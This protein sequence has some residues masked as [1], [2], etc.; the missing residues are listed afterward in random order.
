M[1]DFIFI[2]TNVILP[3]FIPV[4]LGYILS[5]LMKVDVKTLSALQFYILIPALIYIKIMETQIDA[6]VF[7]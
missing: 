3:L 6:E 4:V 2:T 7:I 1:N 5:K